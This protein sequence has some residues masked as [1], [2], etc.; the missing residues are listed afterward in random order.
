MKWRHYHSNK[1]LAPFAYSELNPAKTVSK[2]SERY[3]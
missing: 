1:D 3:T 2:L